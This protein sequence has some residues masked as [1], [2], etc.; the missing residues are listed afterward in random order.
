M[1]ILHGYNEDYVTASEQAQQTVVE[2]ILLLLQLNTLCDEN[3][4]LSVS[5]D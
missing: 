5:I 3:R 4:F 1:S 2:P